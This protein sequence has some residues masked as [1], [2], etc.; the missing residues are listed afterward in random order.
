MQLLKQKC[1]KFFIQLQCEKYYLPVE[2]LEPDPLGRWELDPGWVAPLE[3]EE[4]WLD[5]EEEGVE[6]KVWALRG[7]MCSRIAEVQ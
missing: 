7:M 4:W 5:E 3:L 6:E 2:P 1:E